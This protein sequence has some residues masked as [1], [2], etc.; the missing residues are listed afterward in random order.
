M[1]WPAAA[2]RLDQQFELQARRTPGQI[3]IYDAQ[4]STSLSFA[5]LKTRSDRR[6]NALRARGIGAGCYVGL[7][8]ARTLD[9]V[10]SVLAI[11][12]ADAAVVPLPPTYPE[13]RLRD[14]LA[15]AALDMVLDDAATPLNPNLSTRIVQLADTDSAVDTASIN[16]AGDPDHAAFVLCSSGST[17]TPKMIVRSHRSF[18]H[19]LQWT[20]DNHP[21]AEDE[22]CCLK[23]STTT[24]HAVY[25]LF[26]PLLR[27]TPVCLIAEQQVQGIESFWQT[28]RTQSISRLLLVPSLLQASLDI[29]G[30]TAPPLK[31]LVLMGE[32]VSTTLAQ[33]VLAAFPAHT[34]VFSIYGS[35]EASSSLVCD[36]RASVRPGEGLPLGTPITADLQAVVLGSNGRP[37]AAGEVGILHIAGPALF[38]GYFK[39]AALTASVI[40]K[41]PGSDEQW[42]NSGDQV[43]RMADGALQFVGRIDHTVKVRGFRVD[44]LE[45]ENAL[46]AHREIRQCAVIA[47][48]D[49]Q[50]T[51]TLLAFVVPATLVPSQVIAAM[52][53]RLPAYMVPSLV[54]PLAALPRTTNG[55]VDRQRLLAIHGER[56]AMPTTAF[57]NATEQRV[58]ALWAAQL[59]YAQITPDSCF[60]EIGGTS[61]NAFAMLQRLRDAFALERQQLPD[62]CIYQHQTVAALAAC[63]DGIRLGNPAHAAPGGAILS[64]L[65]RGDDALPALFAISSAGG[66]LAAY[67]KLVKA[68]D[69]RHPVIGVRDPFLWD[70]RDA[71]AGFQ[72]WAAAYVAAIRE[73]QPS[74]PYHVL[75]Y[76]SAGALGY[77]IAQQLRRD[78]QDVALLALIDPLA[79]D[80]GSRYRFGYWALQ[81]RFM[82]PPLARMVMLGGWLRCLLPRALRD[83]GRT[84]ASNDTMLTPDQVAQSAAQSI[85][86]KDH[87][88]ALSA[89]FEL[90]T[91]MGFA[92][93]PADLADA[94]TD[95]VLPRLLA[96]VKAVAA[97]IDPHMIE[98]IVVQYN[99]QVRAHHQYRLQRYPGKVVI[100]EPRHPCNGLLAAQFAAYLQ[101]L[102]VRPIALGE[103]S[104]RHRELATRFPANI[105]SHYL[106]MRDDVFTK[107]LANELAPLLR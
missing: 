21:Y 15:F 76:S 93:A 104:A 65:K 82:R 72:S 34:R 102:D 3:A 14:I 69:T 8:M 13:A 7:H 97:D 48:D 28:L 84:A 39:D 80:R 52:H 63:I 89:L 49:G 66:T 4:T 60:F 41:L 57:A 90:N 99:L 88:L 81:A 100:F 98:N 55:K 25:E 17:G 107:A 32:A 64:I 27:G 67:D 9:Y 62:I 26:E 74:G 30:F 16:T 54:T 38:S 75:A 36:L 70:A 94:P 42:Y 46:L 33:R 50:E 71:T 91:D 23:S 40:S 44:L 77:E 24:T 6:L 2:L 92:M 11:L 53:E 61:L 73:R 47:N 22:V 51:A 68:L 101:H 95:Q 105:R 96:R 106:S 58:A 5:E 18:F 10:V 1:N 19:R 86:S 78:G 31:V 59:K 79:M 12:K 20:W 45:V 43:R 35:T 29:P 103:P 85:A 87:I 83:N 56:A 37:V